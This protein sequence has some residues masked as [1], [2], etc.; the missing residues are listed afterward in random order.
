MIHN[1]SLYSLVINNNNNNNIVYCNRAGHHKIIT[2]R[3]HSSA[4]LLV[5]TLIGDCRVIPTTV[6]CKDLV[7]ERFFRLF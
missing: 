6:E 4:K 5:L 7:S 2:T 1:C 3:H